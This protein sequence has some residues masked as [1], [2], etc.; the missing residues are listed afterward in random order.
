M[1]IQISGT[2]VINDSRQLQNIGSLDSTTAAAITAAGIGGVPSG[3]SLP[4][5]SGN[6]NGDLFQN[7]S[8]SLLYVFNGT[9]GV[10]E[11]VIVSPQPAPNTVAGD[12]TFTNSTGSDTTSTWTAPSGVYNFCVVVVGAGGAGNGTYKGGGGGGG[13]AYKNHIPCNPG[14]SFSIF[15]GRP[16]VGSNYGNLNTGGD[17]YITAYN[18]AEKLVHASGGQTAW[19]AIGG[20][21][22]QMLVGDGGGDG[23]RG[24]D[25][26]WTYTS[27]GGGGAAGYSGDGGNGAGSFSSSS[28]QN[29][30]NGAGGGGG[31][32]G[33]VR[34]PS[35]YS[36]AG[37]GGG[38]G[39]LGE[40]TSGSGKFFT[41]TTG[42]N[43]FAQGGQKGSGGSDGLGGTWSAGSG[44]KGGNYGGGS[45][46]HYGNIT[47]AGASACRIVYKTG[48]P[49]ISNYGFPSTNVT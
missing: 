29:A 22:G 5:T 43:H 10:W 45:G 8:D 47:V 2:T 4:S 36:P 25:A 30:T 42:T 38:V 48:A 15:L 23:G 41:N 32:G 26:Q 35:G 3:S 14:D 20:A 39:L 44:S 46:G 21:G 12:Q 13:L 33:S 16:S 24:G 7:T 40:G 31:G 49:N 37:G 6:T 9:K 1:A 11:P 27:G 19:Y 17:A 18:D 28:G 34:N